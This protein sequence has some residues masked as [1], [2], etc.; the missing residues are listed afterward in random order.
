MKVQLIAGQSASQTADLGPQMASDPRRQPPLRRLAPGKPGV[1]DGHELSEFFRKI[2]LDAL[3]PTSPRN[4]PIARDER[5]VKSFFKA[6]TKTAATLP[7][8]VNF[9]LMGVSKQ[10]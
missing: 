4:F 8:T 10:V 6:A 5:L 3:A 7:A 1:V 9:P 2:R